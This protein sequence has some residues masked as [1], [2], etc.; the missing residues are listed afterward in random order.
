MAEFHPIQHFWPLS[1]D[2]FPASIIL[3]DQKR[4]LFDPKI[5]HNPPFVVN[6]V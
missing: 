3:L 2:F 6:N 4:P 5:R 1:N